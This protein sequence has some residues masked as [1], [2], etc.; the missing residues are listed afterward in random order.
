MGGGHHITREGYDVD[1][2]ISEIKRIRE[3]YNL[4]VYIEPGEAI[5]LNAGYLATEVLDIVENGM[6]ILVLD[7]SATCHMP[8]VLEM[9]YRPPLRNGFEAQEKAH[10]YRLSSNTCL[11]GDVIGDYSFENPVQIGDRF[12]FEDMAIYS[13]VK[14]NT[15][16]G[17]GL[18]SLY[19]MDEQGDCSLVKAFGYQDFKGRLS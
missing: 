5:A 2:L 10:T 19:L 18:P 12:Y 3:T 9:P 11:T 14:N 15:F 8:D 17:I 6:E 13:F 1:L 4:E 16:N 7:A